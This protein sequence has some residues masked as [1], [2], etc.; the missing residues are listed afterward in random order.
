MTDKY[1]L[2]EVGAESMIV[3]RSERGHFGSARVGGNARWCDGLL[4]IDTDGCRHECRS[5][6]LRCSWIGR[7][8]MDT[9]DDDDRYMI[10]NTDVRRC[11]VLDG[12]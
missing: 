12:C 11:G 1:V 4:R 6:F 9:H 8:A 7:V 5:S 2:G 3:E 10:G